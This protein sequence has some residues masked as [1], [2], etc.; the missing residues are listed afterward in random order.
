MNRILVLHGLADDADEASDSI[1]IDL[2]HAI[3]PLATTEHERHISKTYAEDGRPVMSH[4]TKLAACR[5][6]EHAAL[7][8]S[9]SEAYNVAQKVQIVHGLGV[10]LIDMAPR[11]A[12]LLLSYV[13]RPRVLP[14]TEILLSMDSNP[15]T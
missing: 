7:K 8:M 11:N 9:F 3:G 14:D 15:D 6:S 2:S 5:A 10:G 1:G 13:S 12:S 4:G